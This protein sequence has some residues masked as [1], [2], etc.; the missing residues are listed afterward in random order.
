MLD[1][2]RH[3]APKSSARSFCMK[4]H[5]KMKRFKSGAKAQPFPLARPLITITASKSRTFAVNCPE[6]WRL[7]VVPE[8]GREA[9]I[10][11]YHADPK[12]PKRWVLWDVS[13]RRIERPA[14]IHDIEGVEVLTD[15]WRRETGWVRDIPTRWFMRLTA[16]HFEWLGEL[17]TE[18]I[19]HGPEFQ[20][21]H[22]FLDP[23]DGDLS[24]PAKFGKLEDSQSSREIRDAGRY[25]EQSDGSYI[26]RRGKRYQSTRVLGAGVY[27]VKI[28]E[29]A[30]TCL[31]VMERHPDMPD[32]LD[33]GYIT[34]NGRTVLHCRYKR[35]HSP[36]AG[37]DIEGGTTW[38]EAC[39]SNDR[40]S[41]NGETY[42][43]W[44]ECIAAL[45][46]G[47]ETPGKEGRRRTKECKRRGKPRA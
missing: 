41:I 36:A 10:A 3:Y 34:R 32:S 23:D 46:F 40:I 5:L 6:S 15:R 22:T 12:R 7:L 39:P 8:V 45:A 27:R 35:D 14:A 29:R 20:V 13:H 19:C 4:G 25:V 9:L 38:A 30:F 28:G 17:S 42:V 18:C 44:Y 37:E 11:T 26:E 21:L 31:R 33:V 2:I 1:D 16:T 43:A 24:D 47:I